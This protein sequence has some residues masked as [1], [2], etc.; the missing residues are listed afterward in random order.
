MSSA[1]ESS[2]P[3]TPDEG[4]IPPLHIM[5]L[6]SSL[7]NFA[8]P[9][10][11]SFLKSLPLRPGSGDTLLLGLDHDNDKTLIENAYNDREGFTKKFIFNGLKVAGR[12]LGDEDMF[13]QEKWEYVNRYDIA[14]RRHEAFFKSYC[15]QVVSDKSI[16]QVF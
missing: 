12:A 5:F 15:D 14:E 6:G 9:D 2:V 10:A 13:D 7:G 11:A 1:S 3:S 16:Y 4:P 8:R